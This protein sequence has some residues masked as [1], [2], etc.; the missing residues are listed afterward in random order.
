MKFTLKEKETGNIVCE[1]SLGISNERVSFP[2]TINVELLHAA[3]GRKLEEFKKADTKVSAI[4]DALYYIDNLHDIIDSRMKSVD[5]PTGAQEGFVRFSQD[6][7]IKMMTIAA[8]LD[9]DTDMDWT[10]DES[11]MAVLFWPMMTMTLMD[12]ERMFSADSS[13]GNV[14]MEDV[15][16]V[17]LRIMFRNIVATNK[18]AALSQV[19]S[20]EESDTDGSNAEFFSFI[21]DMIGNMSAEDEH[22]QPAE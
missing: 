4:I 8:L 22:E 20:G 2:T 5:T 21:K 3:V 17:S 13:V 18:E 19:K 16:Q 11:M 9:L 6:L 12:A 7:Y 15:D 14:T 1:A 10:C